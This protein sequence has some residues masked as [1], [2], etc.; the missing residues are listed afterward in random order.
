MRNWRDGAVSKVDQAGCDR[1]DGVCISQRRLDE[2]QSQRIKG[3]FAHIITTNGCDHFHAMQLANH[4]GDEACGVEK[5]T[6]QYFVA[7]LLL[8]M[9]QNIEHFPVVTGQILRLSSAVVRTCARTEYLC[10]MYMHAA[11][12]CADNAFVKRQSRVVLL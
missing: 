7:V 6:E 3:V 12:V 9:I 2:W 10:A 11:L 1:S 4:C 5:K 8:Q